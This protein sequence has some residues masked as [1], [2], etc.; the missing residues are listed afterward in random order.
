MSTESK[1]IT[2]II[3]LIWNHLEDTIECL[4]SVIQTDY[5]NFSIVIVDNASTDGSAAYIQEHYP[6][7]TI[8]KNQENLGYAEGNNVGM[9]YALEQKADYIFILNNDTVIK[10]DTIRLLVEELSMN[11]QV[12]AVSP[13]SYYYAFPEK[14]YYA[15]GII[16]SDG[17]V[18]HRNDDVIGS[19]FVTRW[20]NG[21]AM[22]IRADL[23][24]DVGLLDKIFYNLFEDTDWSLRARN[25]GYE[26][27]VNPKAILYHKSAAS[28]EGTIAPAYVYYYHRNHLLWIDRNFDGQLRSTYKRMKLKKQFSNIKKII[29]FIIGYTNNDKSMRQAYIDY[30]RKQ[31]Y[32]RDYYWF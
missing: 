13:K 31:F 2:M 17:T 19:S 22:L 14:V 12:I 6:E 29:K 16:N 9:R 21:C 8:I 25:K 30:I 23:L 11:P 15:G 3:I 1:P 18:S 26:L 10:P 4:D 5:P 7:T 28:F 24:P 32:Q 20:L 27:R